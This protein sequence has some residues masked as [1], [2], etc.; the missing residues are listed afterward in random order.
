MSHYGVYLGGLV[1]TPGVERTPPP[2]RPQDRPRYGTIQGA[3]LEA[4]Q[5][6]QTV[7]QLA[8]TLGWTWD[9]AHS[10][11]H[12]LRRLGLVT[13]T[14]WTRTDKGKARGGRKLAGVYQRIEQS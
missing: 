13:L 5:A 2:A 3:V 7:A 11:L 9:R 14:G 12:H 10:W 4:L 6:P 8:G 1:R